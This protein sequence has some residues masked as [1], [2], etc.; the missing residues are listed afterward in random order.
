MKERERERR[1]ERNRGERERVREERKI[2]RERRERKREREAY[3]YFLSPVGAEHDFVP[4]HQHVFT[5]QRTK[6]STEGQTQPCPLN[7]TSPDVLK[8]TT[9]TV[10]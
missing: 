3:S 4:I 1:G 7:C 2:K 5:T 6:E 9:H 8:D 10:T